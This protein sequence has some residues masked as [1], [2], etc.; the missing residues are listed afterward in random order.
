MSASETRVA[1]SFPVRGWDGMGW[2][3][4]AVGGTKQE[5]LWF[6]GV[7]VAL[8]QGPTNWI[9]SGESFCCTCS[10]EYLLRKLGVGATGRKQTR[11]RAQKARQGNDGGVR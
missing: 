4:C 7:G 11:S 2:E 8:G 1:A 5:F 9:W 6:F 3:E 10:T